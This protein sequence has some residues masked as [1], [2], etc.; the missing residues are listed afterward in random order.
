MFISLNLN[1]FSNSTNNCSSID[2]FSRKFDED[3]DEYHFVIDYSSNNVSVHFCDGKNN[4]KL[5]F[6]LICNISN[7]W[8]KSKSVRNNAN[9]DICRTK[10]HK[11]KYF[12]CFNEPVLINCDK[13]M[14][15]KVWVIILS[16]LVFLLVII[17][18]VG[19]FRIHF[20]KHKS[21]ASQS[22]SYSN[23]LSEY[24]D[25][26]TCDYDLIDSRYA[27]IKEN[28]NLKIND[29]TLNNQISLY[30][31]VE[32]NPIYKMTPYEIKRNKSI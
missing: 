28:I 25:Y 1:T 3:F 6:G 16:A 22:F 15:L 13:K 7:H 2:S 18:I 27:S 9:F 14:N 29:N 30:D 12:L 26:T 5:S 31:R 11:N 8:Y 21:K 24:N 19:I 32:E 23:H 10:N 4:Y 17:I 20:L